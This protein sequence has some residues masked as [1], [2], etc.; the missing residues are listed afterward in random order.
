MVLSPIV[1]RPGG[2]EQ[3]LKYI[4]PE[5]PPYVSDYYEPFVGGGAVYMAMENKARNFYINDKSQELISVYRI[6]SS[7]HRDAFFQ[8]LEEII[9]NREVLGILI[10]KHNKLLKELFKQ[11]SCGRIDEYQLKNKIMDFV[12]N[13][14]NDFN[15]I[16]DAKFND[17]INNFIQEINK[18]LIRKM[19]RMHELEM[20]K[21]KL[22][23]LGILNNIETAFKSAFYTHFRY[24]YNNK[25]KY[26]LSHCHEVGIFFFIRNYAYAGMFR[27]NEK[28]EF[29]VPYGGIGYNSKNFRKKIEYLKSKELENHLK[30]TTIYN[31]DFEEFLKK[32]KPK[33]DDFLFLDPP[34]D[35]E[36]ST[37][38]RNTFDKL[39]Q[40]R[41]ANY[42]IHECRANWMMIIKNTDFIYNLYSN[43]G[44]HIEVFEKKYL[45][46]FMNRNERH[47]EHL[48][49]T[50]Y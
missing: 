25:N 45:V 21:G 28:G 22:D 6:L 1:K 29:N 38:D 43:R 13:N 36:F 23:E 34:Y 47:V 26:N 33:K 7:T 18:S 11:F 8:F 5:L 37:Y 30:K 17:D 10:K 35:T 16:F 50:N 49:I 15:G 39:D 14:A 20:V 4:F 42:L 46:S 12:M 44:L 40:Q 19:K 2:K 3:E 9:H 27:F 31:S 41:L 32:S 48:L 24:L